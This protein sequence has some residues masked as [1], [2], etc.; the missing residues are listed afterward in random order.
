[1]RRRISTLCVCLS[2][3]NASASQ[4]GEIEILKTHVDHLRQLIISPRAAIRFSLKNFKS[5]NHSRAHSQLNRVIFQQIRQR[6]S[7]SEKRSN[8]KI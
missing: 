3:V 1:M 8:I 5:S 4:R 7:V 6:S 2:K